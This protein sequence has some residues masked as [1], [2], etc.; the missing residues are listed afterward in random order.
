MSQTLEQ[1]AAAD[2][3]LRLTSNL[4]TIV[5]EPLVS[6]DDGLAG[7]STV[8]SKFALSGK[9]GEKVRTSLPAFPDKLIVSICADCS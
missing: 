7:E 6:L 9:I 5:K 8:D 2:V 3:R 4:L 1:N